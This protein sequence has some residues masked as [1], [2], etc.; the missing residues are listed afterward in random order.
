M[1]AHEVAN[2][3][4]IRGVEAKV[5]VNRI[6]E[7]KAL[8]Q[9]KFRQEHGLFVAE[10]VKVIQEALSA[11]AHVKEVY[12]SERPYWLPDS[13]QFSL[14]T[15]KDLDR[16]TGMKSPPGCLALLA[17]PDETSP[18]APKGFV[19]ALDGIRDPGNLGTLLR[20]ADW[21]GAAAVVCTYDTVETTNPKVIQA[22]MGSAFRMPVFRTELKSWLEACNRPVFLADMEG[23]PALSTT[24]PHDCVLVIGNESHG[25]RLSTEHPRISIPRF[26]QAESLNAGIAAGILM[27]RYRQLHPVTNPV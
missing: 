23:E 20:T 14:A 19:L 5:S 24:L 26:G 15:P 11:G 6:K 3:A 2:Y 1:Y 21:F 4:Q 13:V 22:A 25:I 8:Q 17:L 27:A 16:M 9:K 10:G 18:P 12:A 7:I